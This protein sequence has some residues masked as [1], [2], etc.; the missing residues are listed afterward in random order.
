[1]SPRMITA[2]FKST[3]MNVSVIQCY[4]PT[5]SDNEE[6]KEEFYKRLQN[7]LDE[8]PRRCINPNGRQKMQRWVQA[9]QAGKK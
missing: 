7:V 9:T 5:N 8:T 1:M 4:V 2:R 6:A 3:G